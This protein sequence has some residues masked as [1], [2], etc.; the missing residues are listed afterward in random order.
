MGCGGAGGAVRG[1][2]GASAA[3]R[4]ASVG[5]QLAARA[6]RFSESRLRIVSRHR[7]YHGGGTGRA[8]SDSLRQPVY[9]SG[10]YPAQYERSPRRLDRGSAKHQARKSHGDRKFE[11]RGS[12]AAAG[13]SGESEMTP[14][15]ESTVVPVDEERERK[16]LDRAWA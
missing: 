13:L 3:T 11:S 6:I 9:D 8:R 14:L 16:D 15:V 4:R 2:D 7:G 10:R 5:C 12:S 1:V